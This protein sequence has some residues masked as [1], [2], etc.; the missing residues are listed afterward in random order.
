MRRTRTASLAAIVALSAAS[1]VAGS[2][3]A[4][5]AT[6]KYKNCTAFHKTYEHGVGK[7][8]AHDKVRG[9]SKPVTSFKV[10]TK[11]YKAAIRANSRLDADHD[12]VACEAR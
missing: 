6:G 2:S 11:I 3:T 7:K 12:G 8:G 4:E 10:S 9:H 5:A 1:L